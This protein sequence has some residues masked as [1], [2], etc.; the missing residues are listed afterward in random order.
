LHNITSELEELKCGGNKIKELDLK[1]NKNLVVLDC[2]R[3]EITDLDLSACSN[4]KELY[5]HNNHLSSLRFLDSL[6]RPEKL[7]HLNISG[8]KFAS[9]E[10][11]FLSKFKNLEKLFIGDN[12]FRGSLRALEGMD[13]LKEVN[14]S[15]TDI[16]SGLEYLPKNL[17]EIHCEITKRRP[18]ALCYVI[19][20]GLKGC[21]DSRKKTYDYKN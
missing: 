12:E 1:N 9:R 20:E 5:C 18:K 14:I 21:Y 8:N 7:T 3:N 17:K 10:L 4:L 2:S 6:P 11:N 16:D 15:D 13:N 19:R